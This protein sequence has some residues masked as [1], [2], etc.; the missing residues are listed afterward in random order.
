MEEDDTRRF[1]R[2]KGRFGMRTNKT[3]KYNTDEAWSRR[4]EPD[5]IIVIDED[6]QPYNGG[7]QALGISLNARKNGEL[8]ENNNRNSLKSSQDGT[9][10]L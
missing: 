9:S 7:R 3:L 10:S 8:F 5:S 4:K 6:N 2:N 1:Q